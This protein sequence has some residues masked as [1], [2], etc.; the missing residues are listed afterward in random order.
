MELDNKTEYQWQR[1]TCSSLE[2][3]SQCVICPKK[4]GK[5]KDKYQLVNEYFGRCHILLST[6]DYDKRIKLR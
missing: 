2:N 4:S 1:L 5:V 3:V 6:N